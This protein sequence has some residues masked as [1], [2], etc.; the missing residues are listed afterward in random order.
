VQGSKDVDINGRPATYVGC[1][2]IHGVCCGPNTFAIA[3][4]APSVFI[5]GYP[6]ARIGDRTAH[7]GGSGEIKTGSGNVIIGNGQGRLFKEAAQTHAPFVQNIAADGQLAKERLQQNMAY[8]EE[9]GISWADNSKVPENFVQRTKRRLKN[10]IDERG[11]RKYSEGHYTAAFI[12]SIGSTMLDDVP[13]TAGGA[14]VGIVTDI[15]VGKAFKVIGKGGKLLWKHMDTLSEPVRTRVRAILKKAESGQ[16]L[17][18]ADNKV[19]TEAVGEIGGQK[20]LARQGIETEEGF[21]NRYHG[22]D[23]MGRDVDGNLVETEFKGSV[24]DSTQLPTNAKGKRQLSQENNLKRSK[25]MLGKT[26]KVGKASKRIG[27]A[28]TKEEMNLW[29]NIDDIAGNKVL[30]STHTNITTGEVKVLKRDLKGK[31]IEQIDAFNI[32]ED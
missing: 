29:D 2:G 17:T 16:K 9:K 22:P 12:D 8:L 28:Y 26:G 19:I 11:T 4:G 13:E 3:E 18:H 10:Y 20:A 7:C 24:N 23:H 31:I 6:A 32:Y 1:R 15:V 21:V 25:K 5:N 30:Q 14:I 27:G